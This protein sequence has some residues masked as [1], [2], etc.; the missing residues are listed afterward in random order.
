MSIARAGIDSFSQAAAILLAITGWEPSFTTDYLP[1]GLLIL[2][3]AALLLRGRLPRGLGASLFAVAAVSATGIACWHYSWPE[4]DQLHRICLIGAGF[5][6]LWALFGR[7]A[8]HSRRLSD[9]AGSFFAWSLLCGTATVAISAHILVLATGLRFFDPT[10]PTLP[11][12]GLLVAGGLLL[13]GLVWMNSRTATRLHRAHQNPTVLLSLAALAVWWTSLVYD[14]GPGSSAWRWSLKC[15]LGLAA[16]L[17]V[18]ATAQVMLYRNRRKAAWPDRL[19]QLL[20]PYSRWQGYGQTEALVAGA[21]LVLGVY[22]ITQCGSAGWELPFACA[23]ISLLTGA[24]CLFMASRRW[25]PNTAGLG[26][27]LLTLGI[28]AL[29]CGAARPFLPSGA[30]AGYADQMPILLNAMLAA[31]WLMASL[32]SWLSRFWHQQLLDGRAWTTT[33]RMIPYAQ[34]TGFLLIA[35]GVLLAFELTLWPKRAPSIQEES[36]TRI[37]IGAATLLLLAVHA[38]REARRRESIPTAALAMAL[39]SALILFVFIRWPASRLKGWVIQY[40]AVLFSTLA[41]PTFFASILL[42]KSR[43]QSFGGPLWLA[44]VF[45]LPLRAMMDI[46]PP[47]NLSQEWSN[48]VVRGL[49]RILYLF[50]ETQPAAWVS[51]V[52]LGILGG[53]YAAAGILENRRALLL[54]ATAF[55]GSAGTGFYRL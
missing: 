8:E 38:T 33:G 47:L 43:W 24:T 49:I 1:P 55:L 51:P 22:Q 27:A 25:S 53:L 52:T 26:M 11:P 21:V 17:V 29:T 32:W 34:R 37:A 45:I 44:A 30:Y 4:T 15:Q 18:A 46:L 42:R 19:D 23:G 13:A 20:E 5:S 16:L 7:I 28:V 48:A 36:L 41:L 50:S 12:D 9:I 14:T 10:P 3:A 2:G 40:D 6:A 35:L 54:L 39:A 31:L